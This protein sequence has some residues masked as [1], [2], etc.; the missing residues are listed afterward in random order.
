[1]VSVLESGLYFSQSLRGEI[2]GG[3]SMPDA[4]RATRD[5]RWARPS[6]FSQTMARA[7][8]DIM[9]VL[10]DVKVVRQWAGPYDMSPDGNP[11][12][13]EAPGAPGFYV[14]C[15]FE[16]HGF[17]MAPVVARHYARML[18]GEPPH[19]LFEAWRAEPLRRAHARRAASA[20]R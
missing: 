2:V 14:C 15:G 19:A 11:I 12:V 4:R 1:M 6:R 3:I 17:M 7:I 18:T 8:T 9:P 5:P 16:G 10:G 13:G 20:R